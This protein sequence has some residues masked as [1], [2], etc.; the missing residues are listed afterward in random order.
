MRQTSA[1]HSNG[2]RPFCTRTW[3][4]CSKARRSISLASAS[5]GDVARG[6][7][8][9]PRDG[10]AANQTSYRLRLRLLAEHRRTAEHEPR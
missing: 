10:V 3:F 7:G 6:S 5:V 1:S 2:G 9:R 8:D 4:V